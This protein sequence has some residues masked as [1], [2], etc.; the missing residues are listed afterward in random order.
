ME[1]LKVLMDTDLGD[2]V[3][4]AA[5]L[6]LLLNS[7]CAELV[8][9]TTVFGDTKRR[10]EMV[11]EMLALYG[12]K[13]VPVVSGYGR[14]MGTGRAG[15]GAESLPLPVQWEIY[16]GLG[17]DG[18]KFPGLSAEDFIIQKA[19]EHEN[20][21][22]FAMGSMTNLAFAFLKEPELMKHVRIIGMGGAFYDA[23]PEWNIACDPEAARIV[24]K[25][26][27]NLTLMGLD[28]TRY[29][30]IPEDMIAK[31]RS[32]HETSMDYFLKGVDVFRRKTG[33][34]VTFHDAL[35]PA[36]L[37]DSRVVS[38]KRGC[39]DV[40]TEGALTR[41]TLVNLSNYY[42][43]DPVVDKNFYFARSVDTDL[44]FEILEKYF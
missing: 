40:E 29:L 6:R 7:G 23:K 3:D 21:V 42:E 2:D 10:A 16:R 15:S 1:D 4:D 22:I 30:K 11:R 17:E 34:P 35:L 12:R 43:V 39:Y 27:E 8:G 38:L 44:F 26:S 25:E 31:W 5:A 19:R 14:A 28:V 20:L 37:I 13:E 41:G 18:P 32:R 33:Y 24:L 36:F 9:V